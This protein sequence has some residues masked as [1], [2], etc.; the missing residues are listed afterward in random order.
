[1]KYFI[2]ID[3]TGILFIVFV[4][5]ITVIGSLFVSYVLTKLKIGYYLLGVKEF[6]KTFREKQ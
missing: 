2:P 3:K 4:T 6:Y 1:V 5:L